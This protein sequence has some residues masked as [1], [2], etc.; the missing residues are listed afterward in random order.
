VPTLVMHHG[1]DQVVPIAESASPFKD[2]Q[3]RNLQIYEGHAKCE[4]Y[5]KNR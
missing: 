3:E 1:A 4:Q 5:T 2:R